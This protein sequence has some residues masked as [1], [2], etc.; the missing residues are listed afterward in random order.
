M[1]MSR[2]ALRLI[3]TL[4]FNGEI[5]E[6]RLIELSDI[7]DRKLIDR[8]TVSGILTVE[9]RNGVKKIK[10]NDRFCRKM[11]NALKVVLAKSSG[12]LVMKHGNTVIPTETL[13]HTIYL[14][15]I[16]SNTMKT[17]HSS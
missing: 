9:Y 14:G 13:I 12:N 4:Y 2:Q 7:R 16:A 1:K 5:E 10:L 15:F 17:A 11:N 8:L 6:S 3:L